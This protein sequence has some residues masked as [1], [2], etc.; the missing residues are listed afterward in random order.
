MTTKTVSEVEDLYG[1]LPDS[2]EPLEALM[3]K[4]PAELGETD[5]SQ[6]TAARNREILALYLQ[7]IRRIKLLTSEE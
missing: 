2:D 6:E 4:S 3:S 1:E 7:D 5:E